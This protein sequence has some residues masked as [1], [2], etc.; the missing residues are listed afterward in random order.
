MIILTYCDHFIIY[1]DDY[2]CIALATN[3][4]IY[5]QSTTIKKF[6]NLTYLSDVSKP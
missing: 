5:E 2:K 6:L 4:K 1:A 3:I